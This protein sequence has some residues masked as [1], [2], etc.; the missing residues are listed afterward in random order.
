MAAPDVFLGGGTQCGI[1]VFVLQSSFT[2][3]GLSLH[4]QGQTPE[5]RVCSLPCPEPEPWSVCT[6][7]FVGVLTSGVRARL[8]GAALV[9]LPQRALHSLPHPNFL[10][11]TTKQNHYRNKTITESMN[12]IAWNSST[13]PMLFERGRYPVP[14][15]GTLNRIAS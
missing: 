3:S 6:W 10:Q 8:G 12:I 7:C 5:A 15:L 13:L 11:H 9:S 1:L 4:P 2:T 14:S